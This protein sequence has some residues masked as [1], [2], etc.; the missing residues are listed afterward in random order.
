MLDRGVINSF[1]GVI[2]HLTRCLIV[3]LLTPCLLFYYHYTSVIFKLLVVFQGAHQII[4]V[5]WNAHTTAYWHLVL[6]KFFILTELTQRR[7][8]RRQV[9]QKWAVGFF[10]S[11]FCIG[12]IG[13]ACYKF[14]PLDQARAL[15]FKT[16]NENIS[17]NAQ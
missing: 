4:M 12:A 15:E 8:R 10:C 7:R 17:K 11:A 9:R 3:L 5:L 13:L 2:S 6:R 14:I 1:T 16:S